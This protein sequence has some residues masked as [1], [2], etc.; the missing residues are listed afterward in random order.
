M[1][2]HDFHPD[3]KTLQLLVDGELD[4]SAVRRIVNLAEDQPEQWRTI[5]MTFIEDQQFRQSFASFDRDRQRAT[6]AL[7]QPVT[8][9]TAVTPR[10][11]SRLPFTILQLLATAAAIAV[12]VTLGFMLGDKN[13]PLVSQPVQKDSPSMIASTPKAPVTQAEF[14]P[15]YRMELVN[16]DGEPV[17]SEVELYR[18]EDLQRIT[19]QQIGESFSLSQV[20]PNSG[21]TQRARDRLSRSGYLIDEDTRYVSG[22][23]DDG[24]SFVVPVRSYRLNTSN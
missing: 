20:L 10:T 22:Q 14:G 12:A 11:S 5:A 8:T 16:V 13:Q 1:P 6:Q 23:L 9:G 24:R 18:L 15:E 2:A 4:Q 17:G 7:P 3:S 19:G 21:F